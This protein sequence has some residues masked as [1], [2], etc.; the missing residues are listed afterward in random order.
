M[1]PIIV[2]CACLLA[3]SGLGQTNLDAR[4][5]QIRAGCIQGRRIVCGRVLEVTPSGLVV[6]CGYPRLL[7]PPLN[8]SWLVR[9]NAAPPRGTNL[10][11]GARP[12]S[13]AVGP[14][15]LTDVPKRPTVHRY[16][17][18]ALIGYPA[19]QYEYAP[20]PGVKKTI[21]RFAAGLER[22]VTLTMQAGGR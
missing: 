4:A 19:G 2:F 13:I 10:V 15:F 17:Y 20:V 18:V 5:E 21:R 3:W 6:D 22:A 7:Q 9:A 16:D 1:K 8:R 12:D 11:E 14:L